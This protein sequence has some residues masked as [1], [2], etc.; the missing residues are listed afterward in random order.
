MNQKW[1]QIQDA[2]PRTLNWIWSDC[3]DFVDWLKS[4]KNEFF[5][6]C[7]K[8]G[9][10]KSTL[11]KHLASTKQT[12]DYLPK[13]ES[14]WKRVHFC[15]D[16]RA[17]DGIANTPEG[18]LRSFTLQLAEALD[19]KGPV[20]TL[21][22]SRPIDEMLDIFCK[23][24]ERTRS[25]V[26]A[27]I[28]GLDEFSGKLDKLA[29]SVTILQDRSGIRMC[30]ASRPEAAFNSAFRKF[31][32]IHMQDHNSSGIRAYMDSA[33]DFRRHNFISGFPD[34]VRD[35]V[36]KRAQGVFLWAR[37]AVDELLDGCDAGESLEKLSRKL[38]SF[39][40]ELGK[41]YQRILNK[42]G[43]E[44]KS[45]AALIFHLVCNGIGET[46][47]DEL[48]GL[49]TWSL[50]GVVPIPKDMDVKRFEARLLAIFGSLLDIVHE[51]R[52]TR[53]HGI[54]VR[55]FHKTLQS[56][57]I[58]YGWIMQHL[59]PSIKQ[60]YQDWPWLRMYASII[61]DAAEEVQISSPKAIDPIEQG[62]DNM[63]SHL[64]QQDGRPWSRSLIYAL[65]RLLILAK[66]YEGACGSSYN[67]IERAMRTNLLSLYLER[68]EKERNRRHFRRFESLQQWGKLYISEC[69]E[70]DF[71]QSMTIAFA[72][73]RGLSEYFQDRISAE[74]SISSEEKQSLLDLAFQRMMFEC[75]GTE[76][77]EIVKIATA[78][79]S[80]LQSRHLCK[81]MTFR[82]SSAIG[83]YSHPPSVL[84]E[85]IPLCQNLV[86]GRPT[87]PWPWEH[88]P[89]CD[90]KGSLLQDWAKYVPGTWGAETGPVTWEAKAV[91]V[92]L[93]KQLLDFL[94]N[95]GEPIDGPC[96]SGGSVL[97]AILEPHNWSAYWS[98]G[99]LWKFVLAVKAGADF[100]VVHG[101]RSVQEC[102]R[103]LRRHMRL[104][105]LKLPFIRDN[106]G[107]ITRQHASEVDAILRILEHHQK[108]GSWK[109][110]DDIYA[111]MKEKLERQIPKK[112]PDL[113]R[114]YLD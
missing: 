49:W 97:H 10:G 4:T 80:G 8:P 30:L 100:R 1:R 44:R 57:L 111:D 17:S 113:V 29:E 56:Y 20:L 37:F 81:L 86:Q 79:S 6:I 102:A 22:K 2:A 96:Y 104:R 39:P 103:R 21:L 3:P 11:M 43:P 74:P 72:V 68:E 42:L 112:Y 16:F 40:E 108:H 47:L 75:P 91:P 99:R 38:D 89:Y 84:L 109:L 76:Q 26:L 50:D 93:T 63:L 59:P 101:R 19:K 36:T 94:I 5:W 54:N 78:H 82:R 90:G 64:G 106:L 87:N 69:H 45:E 32:N 28:D 25:H 53:G 110:L 85:M 62:Q 60:R 46:D 9:S 23:T 41:M 73:A 34:A 31:S 71:S 70:R 65:E 13:V 98:P 33:I 105:R 61:E 95:T 92:V 48:F 51:G 88:D 24:V 67:I 66:H 83:Y 27:F 12:L 58:S 14:T 77:R 18:M 52:G 7:G 114:D 107:G 15:F 55:A 35:K